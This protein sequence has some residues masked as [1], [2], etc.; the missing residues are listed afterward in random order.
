MIIANQHKETM[1]YLDRFHPLRIMNYI[2]GDYRAYDMFDAEELCD[3]IDH[4]MVKQYRQ[5]FYHFDTSDHYCKWCR[6]NTVEPL[7]MHSLIHCHYWRDFRTKFWNMARFDLSKIASKINA[8]HNQKFAQTVIEILEF[9]AENPILLWK[10]ICGGNAFID[11]TFQHIYTIKDINAPKYEFYK[12][13]MS[14]IHLWVWAIHDIIDN[15]AL[16]NR[17]T[18]KYNRIPEDTVFHHIRNDTHYEWLTYRH[19]LKNTDLIFATDSSSKHKLTG[20][21][22]CCVDLN[23]LY[24]M[25]QP[26]GIKCHQ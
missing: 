14:K 10:L 22:L 12:C 9:S 2:R 13:L 4:K 6:R 5:L 18:C 17:Y 8:I 16:T 11:D 25:H 21:G 19:K 23:S 1:T 24:K 7:E 15:N 26:I 20:I 3:Y